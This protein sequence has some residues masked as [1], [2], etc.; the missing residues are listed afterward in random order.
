MFPNEHDGYFVYQ[1]RKFDSKEYDPCK[2]G[3]H[4][5]GSHYLAVLHSREQSHGIAL[6]EFLF[7]HRNNHR[8]IH[9][10]SDADKNVSI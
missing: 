4:F 9:R 8:M 2:S 6:S 7:V 10:S 1:V 3:D 5:A